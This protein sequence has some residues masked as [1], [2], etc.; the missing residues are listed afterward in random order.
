VD[1]PNGPRRSDEEE[2]ARR[3]EELAGQLSH[4]M[5]NDPATPPADDGG[6]SPWDA[7]GKPR[8]GGGDRDNVSVTDAWEQAP[9]ADQQGPRDWVQ[10]PDPEEEDHYIPPEPEPIGASEPL[11]VLSWT[12]VGVALLGLMLLAVTHI[13]V[14]W[15]V[16][17]G[18]VV[19]L[20]AGLGT[21]VWRMPHRR[22]N[23]HDPGA[24]V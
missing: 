24:R 12:A 15:I 8:W 19:L 7:D 2:F 9:D 3:W 17:R 1:N 4:E 13:T 6:T 16:S 11:L 10:G 5:A 14:H 22:E 18:L 20:L 23:P 21:L